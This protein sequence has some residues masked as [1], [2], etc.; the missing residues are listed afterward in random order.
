MAQTTPLASETHEGSRPSWLG[1]HSAGEVM[2]AALAVEL[3]RPE[4]DVRGAVAVH[5][6]LRL[7]AVRAGVAGV[8]RDALCPS[9][10]HPSD[11]RRHEADRPAHP[12]TTLSNT[13]AHPLTPLSSHRQQAQSV[14]SQRHKG[15]GGHR[16]QGSLSAAV[17][18]P[19]F[20]AKRS[21]PT[22]PCS[23]DEGTRGR[24]RGGGKRAGILTK[25]CEHGW[26]ISRLTGS[27]IE[28]LES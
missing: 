24:A 22:F 19:S 28:Q 4:V 9:E 11:P 23:S 1:T 15:V 18:A 21:R 13:R 5:P 2:A 27:K 3:A 6:A 10:R 26:W 12:W 25:N 14:A 7:S 17:R 16:H 8:E 20:F